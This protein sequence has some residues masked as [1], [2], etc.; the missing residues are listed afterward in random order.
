MRG[1]GGGA[2]EVNRGAAKGREEGKGEEDYQT[3]KQSPVYAP[4][5]TLCKLHQCTCTAVVCFTN[6]LMVLQEL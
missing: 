1:I 4:V 3:S 5:I 2:S 6:V